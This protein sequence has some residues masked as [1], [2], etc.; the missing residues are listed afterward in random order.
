MRGSHR[1]CFVLGRPR[2]R[3]D[4]ADVRVGTVCRIELAAHVDESSKF[5][6]QGGEFP[7]AEPDFGELFFEEVRNVCAGRF[8]GIALGED[9]LDVGLGESC[10]LGGADELEPANDHVAVD[11][12]PVGRPVGGGKQLLALVKANGLSVDAGGGADFRDEDA[13]RLALGLV[14]NYKVYGCGYGDH[15][16]VF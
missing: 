1:R 13:C 7:L 3:D 11:P 15:F 4:L 14:P 5:I 10:G 9:A 6:C 2:V 8:T 12:V 16:A